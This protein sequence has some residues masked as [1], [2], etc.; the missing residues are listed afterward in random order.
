MDGQIRG[1]HKCQE[2]STIK[3]SI[4]SKEKYY[5][6]VVKMTMQYNTES[7]TV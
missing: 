3:V 5:T 1:Y 2:P 6:I 7:W 4:K